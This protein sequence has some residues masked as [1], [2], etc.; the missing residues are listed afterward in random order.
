MRVVLAI[1]CLASF[2]VPSSARDI[3]NNKDLDACRAAVA[4]GDQSSFLEIAE[5]MKMW[6][7]IFDQQ[8]RTGSVQC[9]SDGFGES[10]VYEWSS[11]MMLPATEAAKVKE[12]AAAEAAAQKQRDEAERARLAE[13][14][15]ALRRL[16]DEIAAARE[17]QRSEVFLAMADACRTLYR[18]DSILALTNRM[19]LDVFLETG[20]PK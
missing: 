19:C 6:R 16:Q 3:A 14:Q 13:G 8:L 15:A 11:G 5:R 18:R 20:L 12:R 7:N 9:L 4:S 10:W 1:A 17:K 2:A